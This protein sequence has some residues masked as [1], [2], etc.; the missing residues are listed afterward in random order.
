MVTMLLKTVMEIFIFTILKEMKFMPNWNCP[1]LGGKFHDAL[2]K[3]RIEDG[4]HCRITVRKNRWEDLTPVLLGSPHDLYELNL[5]AR[6]LT[7]LT[8]EEAWAFDGLLKLE[9][10]RECPPYSLQRLI[11]FT[12]NTDYCLLVPGGCDYKVLGEFLYQNKML[13]EEAMRLLD[14]AEKGSVYQNRLLDVFGEKRAEDRMGITFPG[15]YAEP[16]D[17]KWRE[18]YTPSKDEAD[19]FTQ[20]GAAV[21]LEVTKGSNYGDSM[22]TILALPASEETIRDAVGSVD[23]AS[24][25]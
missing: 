20:A 18:V 8:Q 4:H 17:E 15:G 10:S 23:A 12:Y 22:N 16:V 24:T 14:A 5:L 9:T 21:V 19:Y 6:R 1:R 7:E 2:Q 13:P 25:K 3:A 11:N